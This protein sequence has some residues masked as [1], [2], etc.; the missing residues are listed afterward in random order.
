LTRKEP[1][2]NPTTTA[3]P[4]ISALP[5]AKQPSTKTQPSSQVL[6][7]LLELTVAVVV[8]TKIAARFFPFFFF[9]F[10]P[11]CLVVRRYVYI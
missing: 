2:S 4:T 1:N 5:P 6:A 7:D 11:F 10:F 8:D 3:K 9:D